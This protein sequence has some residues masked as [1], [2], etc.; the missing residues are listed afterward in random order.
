VPPVAIRE[1]PEGVE[2]LGVLG[3]E[4]ER[5]S[6]ALLLVLGVVRW[7]ALPSLALAP[8][9]T[10]DVAGDA[11]QPGVEAASRFVAVE[12]GHRLRHRLAD[13]VVGVVGSDPPGGVGVQARI[14][15][16][17]EGLPRVDVAVAGPGDQLFAEGV[18]LV[19][20]GLVEW[21]DLVD[22]TL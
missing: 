11:E 2:D 15:E 22:S 19:D 9:V 4:L 13:D 18:A 8:H 16:A 7:M 1:T 12:A 20:L 14:R 5:L 10:D 3:V 21:E 6:R 17:V